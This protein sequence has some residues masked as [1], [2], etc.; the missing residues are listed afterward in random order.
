METRAQGLALFTAICFLVGTLVVIQLW[1]LAAA[2]EAALA[3]EPGVL[4]P[5]TVA[6]VLLLLVNG[7][8]VW[9]VVD[10]DRRLRKV[11]PDG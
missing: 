10:F 5:A 9:Y 3:A 4:L 8:L 6:S 7:G 1:L 2:L 11:S